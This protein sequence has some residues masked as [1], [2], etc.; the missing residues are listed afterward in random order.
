MNIFDILNNIRKHGISPSGIPSNISSK[1]NNQILNEIRKLRAKLSSDKYK[2]ASEL[3]KKVIKPIN[4]AFIKSLYTV[5]NYTSINNYDPLLDFDYLYDQYNNKNTIE[6]PALYKLLKEHCLQRN[7]YKYIILIHFSNEP[8][9]SVSLYDRYMGIGIIKPFIYRHKKGGGIIDSGDMIGGRILSDPEKKSVASSLICA[10]PFFDTQS[11]KD[12]RRDLINLDIKNGKNF[13][14][15]IEEVVKDDSLENRLAG[16]LEIME[17]INDLP[18]KSEVTLSEHMIS[19]S[20]AESEQIKRLETELSNS[21]ERIRVL[22]SRTDIPPSFATTTATTKD[23]TAAITTPATTAITPAITKFATIDSLPSLSAKSA[24]PVIELSSQPTPG[25]GAP[26]PPPPPPGKLTSIPPPPGFGV[27]QSTSSVRNPQ[28]DEP[29][30]QDYIETLEDVRRA[31]AAQSAV[32]KLKKDEEDEENAYNTAD[33]VVKI[34]L[35]RHKANYYIKE[36]EGW[37]R[38]GEYYQPVLSEVEKKKGSDDLK[39]YN[40]SIKKIAELEKKME[41]LDDRNK[42]QRNVSMVP[43]DSNTRK[44]RAS[45]SLDIFKAIKLLYIAAEVKH[46]KYMEDNFMRNRCIK[47]KKAVDKAV[48]KA[49][50][51]LEP[52]L[53]APKSESIST[54][55]LSQEDTIKKNLK[56]LNDVTFSNQYGIMHKGLKKKI[57]EYESKLELEKNKISDKYKQEIASY[58][59]EINMYII[60]IKEIL[61]ILTP[62]NFEELKPKVTQRYKNIKEAEKDI[63]DTFEKASLV[64]GGSLLYYQKYMK[65]KSKYL[66]IK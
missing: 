25:L 66:Q 8:N 10:F 32:T 64:T 17:E 28:P 31:T 61:F 62:D 40:D 41:I 16:T 38:D 51:R 34:E 14:E 26:P 56:K 49:A 52:K 20:E 63:D 11:R 45:E 24:S 1:A 57:A 2:Q 46:K 18:V 54:P 3:Y 59:C 36:I 9:N 15:K 58:I 4:I 22:E 53:S 48:D 39:F 29:G 21:K 65:Y 50:K 43:Q 13:L 47:Q 12:I 33:N 7:L 42:S 19:S 60:E 35:N 44:R 27:T 5:L 30:Y 37:I 6:N 23:T 55:L